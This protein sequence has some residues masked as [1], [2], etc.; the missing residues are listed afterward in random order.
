LGDNLE[1]ISVDG[2]NIKMDLKEMGWGGTELIILAQA[3][4]KW[5]AIVIL[6]KNIGAQ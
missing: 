5:R 2:D 6:V 3:R 1:Y 4:E